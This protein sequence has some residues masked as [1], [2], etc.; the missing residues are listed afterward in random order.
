MK[1]PARTRHPEILFEDQHLVVINKPC[2][3]LSTPHPGSRGKSAQELLRDRYR[4][5]G[6]RTIYAVHR[7][8][9]DTSGIMMFALSEKLGIRIMDDWNRLVQER[10]YRCVCLREYGAPPLPD[11]AKL[12]DIIIYNKHGIGYIP[13]TPPSGNR[14][15]T[16]P[17]TSIIRVLKRGPKADLVEVD[18]I[19]GRKNQ[20]RIQMAHLGHPVSGDPNYGTI[21][22]TGDRLALHACVLGFVHPVTGE[23]LKFISEGTPELLSIFAKH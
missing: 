12:E 14:V 17:S 2:G 9:R 6:K 23:K 7:L 20:I 19:T 1:K 11:V 15:K 13:G 22:N 16:Y 21:R 10:T 5:R 18:L 3:M 8:D 4:S